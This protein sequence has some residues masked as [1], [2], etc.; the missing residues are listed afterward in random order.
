MLWRKAVIYKEAIAV[1]LVIL[2]LSL[3]RE[4]HVH[5]PKVAFADKW[6]HMLAYAVLGAAM[7]FDLIRDKRKWL[8]VWTLGLAIP[9]VYGGVIEILQGAFFYPRS[10]EWIDWLADIIGTAIG[11]GLV[12]GIWQ[13]KS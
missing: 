8:W 5:L 13:A 1:G 2:Y 12:A 9:I 6:G 10:A 7:A 11:T 4:P 3:I